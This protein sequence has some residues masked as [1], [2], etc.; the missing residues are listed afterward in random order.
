MA[1]VWTLKKKAAEKEPDDVE[2]FSTDGSPDAYERLSD[3]LLASPHY[4]ERWG[5]FWLD[6]VRFGESDGYEYDKLRKNA[7]PYRDCVIEWGWRWRDSFFA[8]AALR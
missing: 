1:R 2:A 7:W 8:R 3:R 4:G 5:R 6:V